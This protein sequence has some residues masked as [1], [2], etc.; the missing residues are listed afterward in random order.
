V[1]KTGRLQFLS[2][3]CYTGTGNAYP[4]IRDVRQLTTGQTARF[5]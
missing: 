4:A 5:V 3:S 2:A 1:L